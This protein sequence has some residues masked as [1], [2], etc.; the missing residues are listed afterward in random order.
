LEPGEGEV[1][2]TRAHFSVPRAALPLMRE[3]GGA[4]VNITYD[5]AVR[6]ASTLRSASDQQRPGRAFDR[7]RSP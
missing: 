7:N 1:N 4:I 2:L 5:L 6:A 3:Q